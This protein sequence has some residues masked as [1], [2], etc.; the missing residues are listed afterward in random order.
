MRAS[1]QAAASG[2]TGSGVARTGKEKAGIFINPAGGGGVILEFFYV[3][4]DQSLQSPRG[5][6]Q[7]SDG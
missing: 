5:G 4:S 1:S 2:A 7:S 3:L 6:L